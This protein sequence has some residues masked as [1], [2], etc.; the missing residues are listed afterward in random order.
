MDDLGRGRGDSL[1]SVIGSVAGVAGLVLAVAG[2]NLDRLSS[3]QRW[4]LALSAAVML[5]ALFANLVYRQSLNRR[6][7]EVQR[8]CSAVWWAEE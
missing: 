3:V 4:G 5:W 6:S 1:L 7:E 8:A 2:N